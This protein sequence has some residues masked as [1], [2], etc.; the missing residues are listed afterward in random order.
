MSPASK[1]PLDRYT[2][3]TVIVKRSKDGIICVHCGWSESVHG[4]PKS[5]RIIETC[6]DWR[7]AR[8]FSLVKRCGA[9]KHEHRVP[10]GGY[11]VADHA[12]DAGAA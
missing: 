9:L 6:E 2:K 4:H 7:P 12:F 3:C 8:S 11:H 5:E 1:A 10:G